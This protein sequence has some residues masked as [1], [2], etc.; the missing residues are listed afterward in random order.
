MMQKLLE[1]LWNTIAKA[2]QTDLKLKSSKVM[3]AKVMIIPLTD[4]LLRKIQY[5]YILYKINM[6]P[7]EYSHGNTKFEFDLSNYA[8]NVDLKWVTDVDT[9]KLYLRRLKAKIVKVNIDKLKTVSAD[10]SKLSNLVD[11]D[12][13]KKL[14]MIN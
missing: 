10:L 12:V 14:Y 1:H 2:N 11:N 3:S 5:K 6:K 9:S 4:E 13:N 7:Y 8:K